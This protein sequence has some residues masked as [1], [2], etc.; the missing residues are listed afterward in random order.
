[1]GINK[2]QS[3]QI[4]N[5]VNVIKEKRQTKIYKDLY[6]KISDLF[7]PICER[8]ISILKDARKKFLEL[9]LDLYAN[10]IDWVINKINSEDIYNCDLNYDLMNFIKPNDFAE[11][12]NSMKLIQEYSSDQFNKSKKEDVL[13]VRRLS[14]LRKKNKETQKFQTNKSVINLDWK[15]KENNCVDSFSKLIRE[16]KI[17]QK[18]RST[19]NQKVMPL[20][21]NKIIGKNVYGNCPIEEADEVQ[22]PRIPE[23]K[24]QKFKN[25]FFYLS[26]QRNNFKL[27][28]ISR[29]E[30]KSSLN[31]FKIDNADIKNFSNISEQMNNIDPNLNSEEN[32]LRK[33]IWEFEIY[34]DT[35]NSKFNNLSFELKNETSQSYKKTLN[36][37]TKSKCDKELDL[38][39]LYRESYSESDV[40]TKELNNFPKINF[41]EH[42]NQ[43]SSKKGFPE[44]FPNENISI[45]SEN[46]KSCSKTSSSNENNKNDQSIEMKK[47]KK[48]QSYGCQRY[49]I[50]RFSLYKSKNQSYTKEMA[51]NSDINNLHPNFISQIQ[52]DSPSNSLN[53]QIEKY[54]KKFEE[55]DFN[56]FDYSDIC[57]RDNVLINISDYLFEKNSLYCFVNKKCFETFIDKIRLGYDYLLPYHNDLHAVDV[58][59]TCS[60]LMKYL[61]LIDSIEL[62]F[63]DVC[64]YFI[65]AIIHDFKHPGLNNSYQINKKTK[66]ANRYNDISV[67]ENYHVC[68]AFKIISKPNSNI[69]KDLHIEEY[70]VVRKRIV[71][72]VLATD[73]AKHTKAQTSLRIKLDSLK[74]IENDN[75]LNNNEKDSN[76]SILKRLINNLEIDNKFDRQQEILNFLIHSADISNPA[77]P[78]NV[79]KIWT[80]LVMEEFFIQ[81]DLEKKKGLPVSF[82]CDRNTTNIPKS[83]I[84][85]ISNIVLPNFKILAIL[86]ENCIIFVDNLMINIENWKKED[87][88]LQKIS[89]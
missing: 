27:Q 29:R 58:L 82:L 14:I 10:D 62:N 61:N 22:T 28:N 3:I 21:Y 38:D 46:E 9:N 35:E 49:S 80:N 48:I 68:A 84:G 89:V 51:S 65:A 16:S 71:E 7:I 17:H 72:C 1:L 69:F 83:Q 42:S 67:L 64:G 41:V 43:S 23:I 57:G 87:E 45:A 81:G 4:N 47:Y 76:I 40:Q 75:N 19:L 44:Y 60:I 86:S 8:V 26:N 56:I 37:F 59:Q 31:V 70:R 25:N 5:L 18:R 34:K 2:E 73:M 52:I 74:R 11:F 78:F 24:I 66:I 32:N 15:M 77:K 20:N 39:L 13:Q 63:L 12:E 53:L 55:F 6:D 50:S 79:C 85:F 30:S 33:H 36:E 88:K 54:F